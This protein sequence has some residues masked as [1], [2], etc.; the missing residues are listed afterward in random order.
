MET[1]FI[2]MRQQCA[3]L[4]NCKYMHEDVESYVSGDGLDMAWRWPRDG[5]NWP[6]RPYS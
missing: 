3:C 5:R 6:L 1:N 2:P 4:T